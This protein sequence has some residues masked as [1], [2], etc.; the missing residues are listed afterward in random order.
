MRWVL[1]GLA[2]ALLVG[3]AVFTVAVRTKNLATRWRIAEHNDQI[4]S[5]H[6]ERAR[7]E[8]EQ[9]GKGGPAVLIK[10]LRELVLG[11]RAPN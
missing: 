2:F 11:S 3:L 6:V 9:Q 7:R 1:A 4:T 5:L 8:L 10:R